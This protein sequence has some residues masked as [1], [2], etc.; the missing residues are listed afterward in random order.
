MLKDGWVEA[1]WGVSAN[2]RRVRLYT[3]TRDGARHL[4]REVSSLE[5][6]LAGITRVL[7]LARP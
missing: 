4:E 5:H 3:L 7:A 6:M 2:N 1:K